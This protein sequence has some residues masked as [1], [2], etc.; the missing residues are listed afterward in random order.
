MKTE[1]DGQP[2]GCLAAA[3]CLGALALIVIGWLVYLAAFRKPDLAAAAQPLGWAAWAF[4][5]AAAAA[6]LPRR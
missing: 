2:F 4:G 5:T 6:K 3:A 1:I